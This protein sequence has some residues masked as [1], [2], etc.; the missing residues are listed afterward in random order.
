MGFSDQKYYDRGQNFLA[1]S[2]AF[3]G[4]YTA[5]SAANALAAATIGIA[6]FNRKSVINSMQF[7]VV[8]APKTGQTIVSILNGTN[9]FATMT[10]SSTATAGTV[11]K[12]TMTNTASLSTNTFTNTLP[13][14]STVVL[15]NTTTTNWAVIGTGTQPTVAVNG[16]ATASA[17]TWGAYE[18]EAE[19]Q[20]L[21]V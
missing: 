15:T 2:K 21:F 3:T 18:V 8:T 6:S 14:G 5:S 4:T 11:L 9:T 13:N 16:T 17:D 10:A 19:V 7:V 1:D 20:E 12:A